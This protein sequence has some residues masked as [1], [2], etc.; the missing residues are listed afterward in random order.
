MYHYFGSVVQMNHIPIIA[1]SFG[2]R[3]LVSQL[4]KAKMAECMSVSVPLLLVG[5]LRCGRFF[6]CLIFRCRWSNVCLRFLGD[7]SASSEDNT[8]PESDSDLPL[9]NLV[10]RQSAPSSSDNPEANILSFLGKKSGDVKGP[11]INTEV[12]ALLSGF[13]LK[14]IEK[15][16]RNSTM[17]KFPIVA[18]C[19]A[20]QPPVINAEIN[21]CL[22]ANAQKQDNFLLKLQTQLAAGISA[23]AVPFAKEYDIAREGSTEEI[24]RDLEKKLDPLKLFS[25]VFHAISL[26]RRH[27]ILPFLDSEVKKISE[28]CPVDSHLFGQS[29]ME[30]L[31]SSKE[32]RRL[33]STIQK[34]KIIP[35]PSTSKFREAQPST[36]RKSTSLNFKRGPPRSR[37]KKEEESRSVRKTYRR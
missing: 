36:S 35:R 4:L 17:E 19:E 26:H 30:Q 25:D 23:L 21:P 11:V 33:G 14:G 29:F 16:D 34:K 20:L 5:T 28:S 6:R 18:N 37:M 1:F 32:A 31:K 10:G 8:G 12:T 22:D 24:R 9:I 3:N 2:P 13:L 15:E 27:S 7:S